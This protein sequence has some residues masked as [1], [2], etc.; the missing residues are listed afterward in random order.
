MGVIL[1]DPHD[2]PVL[3]TYMS[4]PSIRE[5]KELAHHHT[6]SAKDGIYTTVAVFTREMKARVTERANGHIKR[7]KD[8]NRRKKKTCII[9]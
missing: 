4:Q 1:F 5:V 3:D 9:I 6:D 8:R 2:S 7:G